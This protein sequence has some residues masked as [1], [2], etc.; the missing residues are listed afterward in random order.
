MVNQ[1]IRTTLSVTINPH[2]YQRLKEEIGSRKI[3]GFVEKAIAK[4]LGAYDNKLKREQKA[5]EKKLITG[6]KRDADKTPNKEDKMWEEARKNEKRRFLL[7]E[8][9]KSSSLLDLFS[10]DSSFIQYSSYPS[11]RLRSVPPP[12]PLTIKT[13]FHHLN[14]AYKKRETEGNYG[15]EDGFIRHEEAGLVTYRGFNEDICHSLNKMG[16]GYLKY[17]TLESLVEDIDVGYKINRSGIPRPCFPTEVKSTILLIDEPELFLHPSL[18]ADLASLIKRAAKNDATVIFTTHSPDLLGHFIEDLFGEENNVDLIMAQRDENNFNLKKP[19]YFQKIIKEII[20]SDVKGNVGIIEKKIKKG[21]EEFA[22]KKRENK[23]L[24][25]EGM[26]DYILFNNILRK[27][28]YEE[29]KE[30][31]VIPIFDDDRNLDKKE[32]LKNKVESNRHEKFWKKYGEGK[33]KNK[34]GEILHSD[35]LVIDISGTTKSA[36][37]K[38]VKKNVIEQISQCLKKNKLKSTELDSNL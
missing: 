5:F 20:D 35:K 11:L 33:V 37:I 12:P 16:S 21:Y 17:K 32:N 4:E 8:C 34:K 3:S 2:L 26:S 31:E 6:Y 13:I 9:R 18:I 36:D 30:I 25:V 29:L 14:P 23:V 10:P 28:L 24:F 27:E 15:P 7:P 38:E 22:D 1:R 19:L